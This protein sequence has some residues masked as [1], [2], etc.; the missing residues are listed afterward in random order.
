MA[1]AC[2]DR[3]VRRANTTTSFCRPGPDL[4]QSRSNSFFARSLLGG[5]G[6]RVGKSR[7]QRRL[8]VMRDRSLQL[9]QP[10]LGAR[11]FERQ[12]FLVPRGPRVAG[13][14]PRPPAVFVDELHVR[15]LNGP[16]IARSIKGVAPQANY[17][18]HQFCEPYRLRS[19][20]ALLGRVPCGPSSQVQQFAH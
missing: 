7:Q 3:R 4:A 16:R 20:S 15:G 6:A 17:A 18:I 8:P 14:A 9:A 10:E 2:C 1:G 12:Q 13:S 19:P 5:L 11:D